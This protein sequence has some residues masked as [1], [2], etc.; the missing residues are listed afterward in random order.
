MM[1][2]QSVKSRHATKSRPLLEAPISGFEPFQCVEELKPGIS[3][4]VSAGR[5]LL[6][7]LNRES[8]AIHS[9]TSLVGNF[10]LNRGGPRIHFFLDRLKNLAHDFRTH[11]FPQ[12]LTASGAA[13][14]VRSVARFVGR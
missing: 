6:G 3:H 1:A 4:S 10:E 12:G 8:D 7:V 11:N 14:A 9:H 13:F 5:E 2:G